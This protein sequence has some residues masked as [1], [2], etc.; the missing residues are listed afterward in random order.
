MEVLACFRPGFLKMM[1]YF[2]DECNLKAIIIPEST[3][4]SAA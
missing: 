3:P 1:L 2:V 4:R